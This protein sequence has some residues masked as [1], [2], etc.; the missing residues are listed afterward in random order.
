MQ[1]GAAA[2][3]SGSRTLQQKEAV[4]T[5]WQAL[6]EMHSGKHIEITPLGQRD[7]RHSIHTE[8][9][10]GFYQGAN[11]RCILCMKLRQVQ[12][13]LFEGGSGCSSSLCLSV[14]PGSSKLSPLRQTIPMSEGPFHLR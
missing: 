10:G 8:G 6:C 7:A 3:G 5:S 12:T 14:M 2:A 9:H 13:S 4:P 11:L 1:H